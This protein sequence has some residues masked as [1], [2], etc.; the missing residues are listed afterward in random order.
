MWAL[1]HG[2]VSK[3][4]KLSDVSYQLHENDNL[5]HIYGIELGSCIIE[6]SEWNE[7]EGCYEE[8]DTEDFD[9]SNNTIP[10]E[11]HRIQYWFRKQY[12]IFESCEKGGYL[13]T[14]KLDELIDISK[15]KLKLTECT[16]DL[17]GK[18]LITGFIY[19]SEELEADSEGYEVSGPI[20]TFYDEG[21]NMENVVKSS[22]ISYNRN[23][24]LNSPD[25]ITEE[26]IQAIIDNNLD[27]LTINYEFTRAQFDK[28]D[29][30]DWQKEQYRT[31]PFWTANKKS[32]LKRIEFEIIL[33]ENV[34]SLA[35]AFYQMPSLKSVNLKDTS[36]VTNM[37][38][39]FDGAKS[40][41]QPIGDWDVSNVED[42]M[43]MFSHSIFNN[44]ISKWDVSN[45]EGMSFM[46]ANSIFNGDISK[47]D[48]SKVKDMSRMF[49]SSQ[50]NGDISKWDVSKV[51]D[52][53]N[54]F[55]DA[56][57]FNQPIGDWD[58]SNVTDMSYMFCR[59]ESFNQPIGDWDTSNVRSMSYMFEDAK[60][61]NQP[62]DDWDTSNVKEDEDMF[63]GAESYSY[64]SLRK[65]SKY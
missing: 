21:E 10:D 2:E 14:L 13:I 18:S 29:W 57:S 23:P 1:D 11:F 3:E 41:N 22:Q 8:I 52:M 50:F 39:M 17:D 49:A 9:V 31:N 58:T 27:S 35:Y 26:L 16:W 44:D 4:F 48:V 61:F 19:D 55:K 42:M 53:N 6:V 5:F 28:E 7:K 54:M 64:P 25:D 47:W 62:I 12:M 43:G 38:G 40:F 45:V 15:L 32:E 24:I 33:G 34:H 46:F 59:A 30:D 56:K 60:S 63:K 20:I 51:E 65:K 36:N 37:S